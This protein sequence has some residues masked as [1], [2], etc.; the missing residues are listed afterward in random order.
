MEF[1]RQLLQNEV[2]NKVIVSAIL[3]IVT[4]IAAKLL[5]GKTHGQ[6]R[7]VQLHLSFASAQN[8]DSCRYRIGYLFY[9]VAV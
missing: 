5:S 4:L 1:I 2:W 8:C 9:S 7:T 3:L 6:Q